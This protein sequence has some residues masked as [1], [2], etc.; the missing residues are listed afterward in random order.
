MKIPN[1]RAF[2]KKST[3]TT[4]GLAAAAWGTPSLSA[5][6]ANERLTCGVIGMSRGLSLATEF[7]KQGARIA[8]VC[9]VDEERLNRA[10]KK[11]NADNGVTDLRRI[12]DDSSIDAV[13]I[14]TPDHWHAPIALL[15]C[16]AGKHVYVE[17]PC[18]HNIREGR[19]IVECAR[20]TKRVI[21][22]GSQSRSTPGLQRGVQLLREGAIGEILVAKAWNS[23]RR[24]DIGHKQPSEVPSGFDYDLWVGPAP[25]R[26]FQSNCHHYTWHWWYDFGTGDIGN[27]GIHELDIAAWALGIET[28][29]SAVVGHG[30]KLFFD[31]D[32]QFPDT[33][34]VTFEYDDTNK[35]TQ[36]KLLVYEQ[37]LWS[38]YVQSGF[39][40]GNEFYGTEGFMRMSKMDGWK[41]YGA[42]NKLIKEEKSYYSVPDHVVNFI[43]AVRNGKGLTAQIEVGHRSAVLGHLANILAR[44][45]KDSLRF[46]PRTEQILNDPEAN[47]LVS[48]TYREGHWATPK[49]A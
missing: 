27:D 26:Q 46:D 39:E 40:N 28:H 9:D 10:V 12:L 34:Y 41:L 19:L 37:R 13:V 2:I 48:R 15:A 21:Q 24:Q 35:P 38:P 49:Q 43:E 11:T 1:R 23:Q 6:G 18:S 36:K 44:T 20:R 5:V 8:C 4:I 31:D 7:A 33:Q 32:Q 47:S 45:G 42:K 22:V 17:K 16:E 25:M 3:S 14:A 30:S 29:P